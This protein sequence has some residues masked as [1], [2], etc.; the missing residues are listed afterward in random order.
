MIPERAECLLIEGSI[1]YWILADGSTLAIDVRQA[2]R[3]CSSLASDPGAG[4]RARRG[5]V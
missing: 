4:S 5:P 2:S 1:E 3:T